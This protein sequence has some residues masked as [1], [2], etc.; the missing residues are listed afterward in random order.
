MRAT[1]PITD[2]AR[3]GS[4]AQMRRKVRTCQ[5]MRIDSADDGGCSSVAITAAVAPAASRS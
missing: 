1:S 3:K 2:A 4:D 5:R